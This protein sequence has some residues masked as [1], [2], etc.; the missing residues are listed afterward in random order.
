MTI[1]QRIA[2]QRKKLGISQEALGERMGVSRQAIS[3]WE[4]DGAIPEI[5]KL[6]ALSKLF[7]V[8]VGWLLGTEPEKAQENEEPEREDGLSDEQLKIIEQI[9][10]RYQKPEPKRNPLPMLICLGCAVLAL[11]LSA[12]GLSRTGRQFPNY[13]YQLSDLTN[14]YSSIRSQLFDLSNRLDELAEG[15]KL[16]SEYDAEFEALPDW[17]KAQMVFQAVPKTWQAG[18]AAYLSLRQDGEELYKMNCGW[19]GVAFSVEEAVPYGAYESYF[20]LC[21]ED[22]SQAQQNVTEA[23]YNLPDQL[24]PVCELDVCDFSLEYTSGTMTL[25]TFIMWLEPPWIMLKEDASPAW[26]KL[27]LVI[28]KNGTEVSRL[29][30]REICDDPVEYE[31]EEGGF[32]VDVQTEEVK[33]DGIT[34]SPE[35]VSLLLERFQPLEISLAPIQAGDRIEFVIECALN[36][37]YTFTK[38]LQTFVP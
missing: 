14:S 3:K 31:E 21:R 32:F 25:D 36:N 17:T 33:P 6:I 22:G 18:D 23:F 29:D 28:T 12:V 24:E 16:L 35:E 2:E 13:D 7:D 19:D 30:L 1:G 5:D 34:V 8:S 26:T 27:D 9:V 37:G 10:R 4:A 11:V 15:E 38:V 20:V